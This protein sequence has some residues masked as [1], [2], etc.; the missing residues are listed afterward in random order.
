MSGPLVTT[1]AVPLRQM[2]DN[3][4]SLVLCRHDVWDLVA[5]CVGGLEDPEVLECR[6]APHYRERRAL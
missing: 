2:I 4:R 3:W 1:V 6:G 5:T